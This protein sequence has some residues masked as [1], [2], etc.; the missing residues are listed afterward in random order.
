MKKI[1]LVGVVSFCL[2]LP[3]VS[4]A[5]GQGSDQDNRDMRM[6]RMQERMLGMHAHMHRILEA[7]TPAERERLK[8]EHRQMMR[9]NRKMMKDGMRQGRGMMDRGNQ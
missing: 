6:E 9:E 2:L 8:E 5:Q 3:A 1:V 4:V 7:E